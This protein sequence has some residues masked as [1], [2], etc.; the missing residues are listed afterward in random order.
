MTVKRYAN[1]GDRLLDSAGNLLANAKVL[2]FSPGTETKKSIYTTSSLDVERANPVILSGSGL[3]PT[4]W[5]NGSY[6]VVIQNQDG[7][8]IDTGDNLNIASS[9]IQVTDWVDDIAYP[10][11]AVVRGSNGLLYTSLIADN[12]NNDPVSTDRWE[13]FNVSVT[14]GITAGTTQTQAGATALTSDINEISV[15]ANSGDGVKLPPAVKGRTCVVI[16]NGA[17][18]L[19]IWPDTDD[20]INNGAANAADGSTL[21]NG[22]IRTYIANDDI[23]WY[24][25]SIVASNQITATASGTLANGDTVVLN[26]DGTVSAVSGTTYSAGTAVVFEAATTDAI[27]S[28]YDSTNSRVVVAYRDGGNTNQGTAV[29]GTV[30]GSAISF[31]TPVVFET[32]NTT[33]TAC[34]FDSANGKAVIAYSDG[35]NS[36]HGTAIVGTVSGTSISFGTAVVFEAA[37][38]GSVAAAYDSANSKIVIAY[39]DLGNSSHGTAIVGTVSGTSISFGTPAVYEAAG[40]GFTSLCYDSTNGKLVVVYQDQGNSSFGTAAVGTV[41]G[42]SISFGTPVVF[43]S[44]STSYS[45]PVHDSGNNKIVIAY[46]DGGN[47]SFGTAIVGTISGTSISFGTAAVFES[48]SSQYVTAVYDATANAISIVYQDAGNS[49]YGTTISGVVS[50]ASISFGSA[51]VFE[52]ANSAYLSATYDGSK[53]ISSYGDNGNSTHGTSIVFST[54]ATNLTTENFAGFSDGSY[55]DAATATVQTIGAIND[56]QSSLTAAQKHYV[57]PNG[58]LALTEGTPSVYAGLATSAT[59]IIVKG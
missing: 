46:T 22:G 27:S 18:D 38:T 24:R 43:N 16:N 58:S 35:G 32:G 33:I 28:C 15:C 55:A 10:L 9:T 21:F 20:K 54:G 53:V 56:A 52:S 39:A 41:S 29:V 7:V 42:T 50:G 1:P 47:S 36:G 30:S 12:L 13:L 25:E 34:A 17:Q 45:Q 11:D 49:S 2:F 5:L 37:N 8:Q 59:K 23:D 51:E 4:I 31:G 48:A 44:G 57:Q 14:N 19:Q 40:T 3:I 6:D 26:S